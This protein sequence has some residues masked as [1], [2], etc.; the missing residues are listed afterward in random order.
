MVAWFSVKL[1]HA[2]CL[3]YT[4]S[5]HL[6]ANDVDTKLGSQWRGLV[7]QDNAVLVLVDWVALHLL[8]NFS[9]SVNICYSDVSFLFQDYGMI[10]LNNYKVR[11]LIDEKRAE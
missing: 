4:G 8:P 9:F 5:V 11:V 3:N 1:I 2:N 10:L 7:Q 6:A